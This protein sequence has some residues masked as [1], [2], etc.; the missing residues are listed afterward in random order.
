MSQTLTF[1]YDVLIGL[2]EQ[3]LDRLVGSYYDS[4]DGSQKDNAIP[5]V[6]SFFLEQFNK[7]GYLRISKPHLILSAERENRN[8]TLRIDRIEPKTKE[9]SLQIQEDTEVQL[10]IS[11]N[12]EKTEL[13]VD[14]NLIE[15]EDIY[16]SNELF[17]RPILEALQQLGKI[18]VPIINDELSE[19]GINKFHLKVLQNSAGRNSLALGFF[20]SNPSEPEP[21]P[22]RLIHFLPSGQNAQ[23]RVSEL[24][25]Q[26][27]I[28]EKIYERWPHFTLTINEQETEARQIKIHS[29]VDGQVKM[30]GAPDYHRRRFFFSVLNK[31]TNESFKFTTDNWGRF[32]KT[33]KGN[34][35]DKLLFDGYAYSTLELKPISFTVNNEFQNK[36]DI[37]VSPSKDGEII[38]V[39]KENPI[40]Q[41]AH[42]SLQ[43]MTRG[44]KDVKVYEFQTNE[45]GLFI[46]R[47]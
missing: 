15:E 21:D 3:V 26:Q 32:E 33:I 5:D 40:R 12:E 25:V 13:E 22:N 41:N 39:G 46:C 42:G 18:N 24:L 30:D 45:Q 4:Y 8:I 14:F 9:I 47:Y 31:Q 38:I 35:G 6:I 43:I 19:S 36:S 16:V 29:P 2:G 34:V 27:K 17:R 23:I 28:E 10:L 20:N 7:Q 11:T 1:G 37:Q 44:T